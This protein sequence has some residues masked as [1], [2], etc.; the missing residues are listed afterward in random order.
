[1]CNFAGMN[2][3]TDTTRQKFEEIRNDSQNYTRDRIFDAWQANLLFQNE[4]LAKR[5]DELETRIEAA[6]LWQK[7]CTCILGACVGLTLLQLLCK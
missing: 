4:D 6:D 2:E 5:L 7:V 1:M 3:G